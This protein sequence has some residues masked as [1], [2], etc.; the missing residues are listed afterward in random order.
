MPF[1]RFEKSPI[2]LKLKTESSAM[3]IGPEVRL[4][5]FL[6]GHAERLKKEGIP[7]E[8]DCRVDMAAFDGVYPQEVLERDENKV[9]ELRA[10][11]YGKMVGR[12]ESEGED[13]ERLITAIFQ[14]KLESEFI[15]V[16]SS[17]YDDIKGGVDSIILEKK[18]GNLVCALDE[19]GDISGPRFEEKKGKILG[20]NIK[21]NGASLK[22]G[23]T[24]ER[25]RDGGTKLKLGKVDNLPIFYL[26]LPKS[27]IEEGINSF[28][29][30]LTESS[31]YEQK[32]FAYFVASMNA[33]VKE[34]KLSRHP[35][36][37]NLRA[38]LN[39]FELILKR[40]T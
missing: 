5:T 31:L 28:R 6:E 35:L 18:T 30:S 39:S 1:E 36:H 20:R 25:Q 19:V 21:E 16:R 2:K 33:Q 34:L 4:R 23:F 29:A 13:L 3:E 26:A 12:M 8:K 9:K 7:V 17:R 22:Y 15:V 14:K 11:W 27:Y 37:P 24:L 32:L 38:R 40:F 10:K